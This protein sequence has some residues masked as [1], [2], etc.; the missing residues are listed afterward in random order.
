MLKTEIKQIECKTATNNL[1]EKYHLIIDDI[2]FCNGKGY[3]QLTQKEYLEGKIE[4]EQ[5]LKQEFPSLN[6]NNQI[7]GRY[8]GDSN[9]SLYPIFVKIMIQIDEETLRMY[10]QPYFKLNPDKIIG[11]QLN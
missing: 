3:I 1:L 11:G 2:N 7:T 8:L 4:L 9:S 10:G 6:I 5:D